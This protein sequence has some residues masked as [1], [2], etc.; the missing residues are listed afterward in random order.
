M[1]F[2]QN[3]GRR[4]HIPASSAGLRQRGIP[5]VWFTD[6]VIEAWAAKARTTRVG[7]PRRTS[8]ATLAALTLCAGFRL[9]CCQ[10]GGLNGS[11]IGLLGLALRVP[12]STTLGRRAAALDVPQPTRPGVGIDGRTEP[13]HLL[14]DSAGLKL[15]GSAEWLAGKR[16]TRAPTVGELRLGTGA[17]T[18]RT[19][20]ASLTAKEVDDGAQVGA[21]PDQAEGSVAAFIGGSGH[22]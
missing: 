1:P 10:A 9:A 21:L 3:Q 12:D 7:Q 16:G 17:G 5:T 11:V 8:L 18:G 15:C 13:T 2:K 6:E 20:A 19:M 4:R 22:D 14:E